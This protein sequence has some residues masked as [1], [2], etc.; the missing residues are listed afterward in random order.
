MVVSDKAQWLALP[1]SIAI[2]RAFLAQATGDVSGTVKYAQQ[3]LDHLPEEADHLQRGQATTLLGLASW[4]NGDLEAAR[5]AFSDFIAMIRIAGDIP[6]LISATFVLAEIMMAQGRLR[7]AFR[8]YQQ[9]LQLAVDQGE[10]MPLGTEDLYRGIS[11]LYRERGDLETAT[12]HLLT[13]KQLGDQDS[14]S[15]WQQRW[16][17]SQARLNESL[18]DMDG[19]L[20][21]LDEAERLSIRNPLPDV[22]PIPALKTRIWVRQGRLAEALN[23]VRERSLSVDDDISYLREFEH[24][25]LVRVLIAQYKN[26]QTDE[27]IFKALRLL[28]RLLKAAEDGKRMGSMVN[29]LVLQALVY[30]AQGDILAALVPLVQ[31]LTLAEPESYQCIFVDEGPPMGHLLYEVASGTE[32]L[33]QGIALDYV[34]RL[35]SAFPVEEP[36][37]P[38]PLNYQ[39]QKTKLIDPLSE[40]ELEV[41]QLIAEGLTNQEIANKL[42]ISL[43]TVKVHTRNI[44]SKLDVSS[45]TKAVVKAR[46]LGVLATSEP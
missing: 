5:T 19:A 46:D 45:R 42:Y 30:E 36:Q 26:D 15:D 6:T 16:C 4:A 34:Q 2:A 27:T 24:L 14:Q 39:T 12:Q 20:D 13:S 40:R 28:E 32:A 17:V 35:L 44:N 25:I 37:Q 21:L 8:L 29:I 33:S 38:D 41:L 9:F 3:V 23:W 11:E 31:A 22:H 10:L 7:D 43:N 1:A 18:G